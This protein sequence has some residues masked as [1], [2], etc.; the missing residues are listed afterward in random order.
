MGKHDFGTAIDVLDH[1]ADA[2]VFQ[3]LKS[4]IHKPRVLRWIDG[5][6]VRVG[7]GDSDQRLADVQCGDCVAETD[8]DAPAQSLRHC[9]VLVGSGGMPTCPYCQ[10]SIVTRDGHDRHRL[11]RFGC[12]G[13]GRDFTIRSASAFSGYRW[14]AD[15]ILMAVRW[16]LRHPLSAT[17][18]MELLAERGIDVSNRTV[19]RWVQ[20]FGPQLAAEARKHRRPLGCHWYTDEMFFFRGKDKWYLYR[21]VDEYG[22]VV[23]VVLR[24]HRDTAS[25]EAFFEPALGRSGQVPSVIV[26]DHHQP[27]VKAIQ[28]SVPTAVHIRSG[29]HRATGQTTKPIE[30]SHVPTRDRLRSSRGLKTLRTGQRF[31][32]GFE[33]LRAL[34]GGHIQLA[35][36]LPAFSAATSPQDHVRAMAR[37]VLVLGMHLN[38]TPRTCRR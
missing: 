11:Q 10:Q 28:R 9:E 3:E 31:L 33:C 24:E 14:P 26:T 16:Y 5:D 6:M 34:R 19:L 2:G 27:Y 13:C 38:R 36:L 15:V 8:L 12:G 4:A 21:A 30:R 35:G 7:L 37:A 18:V 20:A 22:K 23:D 32:E 25:A 17:S 1:V 29:L